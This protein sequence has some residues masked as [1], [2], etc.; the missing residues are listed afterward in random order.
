MRQFKTLYG[1]KSIELI[2]YIQDYLAQNPDREILIGCD[3]Q[4]YTHTVQ[5][6]ITVGLYK[7]GKGAHVLLSS[8]QENELFRKEEMA[9]RLVKEVWYSIEV[10][11]D[12]RT[13]IGV[14]AKYI[15]IDINPDPKYKSNKA[16]VSALGVVVGMGYEVRHKGQSPM[17]TRVSDYAVK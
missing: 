17:M 15:D 10:A 3:S 7:P 14:R 1:S 2:P 13:Q 12:I 6:A 8:F 4:V 5:Y 11:E 9:H 16:L